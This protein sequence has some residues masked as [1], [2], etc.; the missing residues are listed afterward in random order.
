MKLSSEPR[1]IQAS[2]FNRVLRWLLF[3]LSLAGAARAQ[4]SA[5]G[6]NALRAS[7]SLEAGVESAQR[8]YLRPSLRFEFPSRF[9]RVITDLDFTHRTNGDLEGEVDF[10]LGAGL[11]RPLSSRSDLEVLI[12]HFCRHKTSRDYPDVLDINEAL[13]R[14]WHNAGT[15][16]L[17]IGGG[18][19]LGKSDGYDGLMAL[20]LSWPRILR[21]EFSAAAEVKWVDFKEVL[22]E[23]ELAVGLDSNTDLVV[24]FTR[25]Y[26][27]P[28]TTYFGFRFNSA[29][30]AER[31]VDQF[32]F[33][34]AFLPD[35]ETRKVA[36]EIDFG[37]HF[38]RT[39]RSQILITMNSEIPVERGKA[40]LGSFRPEE[41]RYRADTVYER[42]VAPDL[43]AFG[44]GR[45]DLRM[46][47]DAAQRF[48]S[49]WGL[50]LGLKNQTYFT[51]LERNFRY[52]LFA[53]RNYS[54]GHDIGAAVGFNTVG[55]PVDM[56]GDIRMELRPGEF[57]ALFELFAEA[58]RKPRVRPFLG[59]ER[60]AA[61]TQG[62]SFTRFFIGVEL[63]AWH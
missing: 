14:Y 5:T 12:K 31:S 21:S 32:R 26:V 57:H 3:V 19:Y 11:S 23:F 38:F 20:S 61:E 58:G 16:R 2:F 44:Y 22:Y 24:R 53:G 46:P 45:Y 15:L 28:P 51:K 50:G 43:I 60:M 25:H 47:I 62:K 52:V 55:K 42:R 48:D 35:D 7:A 9:G 1:T 34:T 30:A 33:R 18:T 17:G 63:A 59:F 8:R 10:W 54:H 40:L 27:Y 49:S 41:L 39:S 4:D 36:A 6:L 37:L 13:V 29:G 56:G